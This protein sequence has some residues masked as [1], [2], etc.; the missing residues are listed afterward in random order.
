MTFHVSYITFTP[1]LPHC[2]EVLEKISKYFGDHTLTKTQ[3]LEWDKVFGV[4]RENVES[5][6]HKQQ[7][8]HSKQIYAPWKAPC[9]SFCNW[10]PVNVL[11]LYNV[12]LQERCSSVEKILNSSMNFFMGNILSHS[13]I[14]I[15]KCF[16]KKNI[17]FRQPLL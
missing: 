6:L 3:Q 7:Q 14:S 8:K 16:Y 13:V 2:N 5:L 17:F 10:K 1:L 11:K 15:S 4:A 9:V 12:Y